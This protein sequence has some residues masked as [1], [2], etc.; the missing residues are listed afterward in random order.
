LILR[1]II[2]F[3]ATRCQILRLKCTKF[4]YGW[5]F[6]QDPLRELTAFHQTPKAVFKG[7][8]FKG[9]EGEKW[10][11][12]YGEGGKGRERNG[13][14][15]G[16]GRGG[17]GGASPQ[18]CW[19]RIAPGDLTDVAQ[20]ARLVV[21]VAGPSSGQCAQPVS[22]DGGGV[23]SGGV[24]RVP[25]V[26]ERRAD[27]PPTV[28]VRRGRSLLEAADELGVAAAQRQSVAAPRVEHRRQ[29]AVRSTLRL[30]VA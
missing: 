23:A 19:P 14:R 26:T 30:H 9:K 10:R 21:A 22:Q 1:N 16:E 17:R 28:V 6:A 18:V 7:S 4:D 29:V 2:K 11:G 3:D 27:P 12:E 25:E 24:Q 15:R 8:T 20:L 13:K 5:G